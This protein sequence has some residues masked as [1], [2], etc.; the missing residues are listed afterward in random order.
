MYCSKC[1]SQLKDGANFCFKCGNKS[2]NNALGNTQKISAMPSNTAPKEIK[3]KKTRNKSFIIIGIII[4]VIAIGFISYCISFSKFSPAVSKDSGASAIKTKVTPS[5]S[6]T[7]KTSNIK[8]DATA[9]TTANDTNKLN[10]P[11]YYIFP[12]S[13]SMELLDSDVS[14]LIKPNLTLARNEIF[15]RHGFIFKTEPFKSYFNNKSWYKQNPTFKGSDEELNAA[16]IYNVQL[17]LK[18]ENK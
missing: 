5:K 16:E 6:I 7:N 10:S 14:T 3:N 11:N 13:G 18:Y 8:P 2:I 4:G 12:K 17:I 1:G 9:S 15:A